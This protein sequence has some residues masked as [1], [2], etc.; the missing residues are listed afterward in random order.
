MWTGVD[1]WTCTTCQHPSVSRST[2]VVRCQRSNVVPS[3][4]LASPYAT[5]RSPATATATSRIS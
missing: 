5:A 1:S 3:P 2:S 4:I